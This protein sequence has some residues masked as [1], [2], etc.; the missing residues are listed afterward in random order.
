MQNKPSPVQH[1]SNR[2][3]SS[4]VSSGTALLGLVETSTASFGTTS[5]GAS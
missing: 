2:E 4:V 1:P 5:L 3:D